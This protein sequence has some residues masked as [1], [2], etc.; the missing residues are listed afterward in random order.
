MRLIDD[1]RRLHR[2]YSVWAFVAIFVT[3]AVEA[4]EPLYA[5][6]VPAYVFPLLV[7]ALAVTGVVVRGI[8]QGGG[9]ESSQ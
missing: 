4:A 8:S 3:T 2:K 6:W 5:P 9:S 7:G 1:W